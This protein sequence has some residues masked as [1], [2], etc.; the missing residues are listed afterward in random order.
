MW[1]GLWI[2]I[3]VTWIFPKFNVE[4]NCSGSR[5]WMMLQWKAGQWFGA[6]KFKHR[7]RPHSATSDRGPLVTHGCDSGL[8]APA[9]DPL[10]AASSSNLNV[11]P[12]YSGQFIICSSI[13][14]RKQLIQEKKDRR[15]TLSRKALDF[16]NCIWHRNQGYQAFGVFECTA[17]CSLSLSLRPNAL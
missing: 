7:V 6:S 11:T 1:L 17:E 5:W 2:V 9:S 15:G 16:S 8:T 13:R 3:Q 12:R 14:I 10:L 4:W